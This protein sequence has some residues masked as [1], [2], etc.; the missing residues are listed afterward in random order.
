MSGHGPPP[1]HV[2]EEPATILGRIAKGI[3]DFIRPIYRW[4][5][6]AGAVVIFG[7]VIAMIYSS[8]GRYVGHPLDGAV[9]IQELGLVCMIAFAMGIEHLGHEKMTVDALI[10]LT[11]RRFQDYVAPIIF[12]LVIAI[13][14]IAA[15]QLTVLGI[16]R[17]DRGQTTTGTMRLPVYPFV[18]I[19]VYGVVTMI[20]IYV[21]RLLRSIDRL[22][23]R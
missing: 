6:W 3:E 8:I 15:W 17:Q 4:V 5:G 19:L 13:L 21:A 18:Y 9:D 14:V 10:R 2:A 20:P 22:V 1:G 12:L 16:E 7:V 11:P 23:K